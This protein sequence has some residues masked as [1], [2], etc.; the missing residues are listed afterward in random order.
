MDMQYE[1]GLCWDSLLR[2]HNLDSPDWC[3]QTHI[4]I[5]GILAEGY[6]G[7]RLLT[8]A[9]IINNNENHLTTMCQEWH[10]AFWQVVSY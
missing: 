5:M 7:M 4:E 8:L 2:Q 3:K 1:Q 9:R 10:W 6:E